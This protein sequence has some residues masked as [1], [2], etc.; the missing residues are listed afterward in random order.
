MTAVLAAIA[1]A[2]LSGVV[3]FAIVS[4][5]ALRADLAALRAEL[6]AEMHQGFSEL[7]A[8]IA[9]LGERPERPAG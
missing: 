9:R 5:S 1:A 4:F 8:E 6:P 2:G 7:R 3:A